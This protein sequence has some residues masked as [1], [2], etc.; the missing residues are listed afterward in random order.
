MAMFHRRKIVMQKNAPPFLLLSILIP[1]IVAA[2]PLLAN[3]KSPQNQCNY[4]IVTPK[5]FFQGAENLAQFR[6][7]FS[8]Y[9]TG[10]VL[11]D[12][13]YAQF[14]SVGRKPF[15]KLW[16]GLKY[17]ST[18]WAVP[19][20]FVVLMGADTISFN[21]TDSTWKNCGDMPAFA[22]Q[23][24]FPYS[25][26]GVQHQPEFEY[27]DDYY[28]ELGYSAPPNVAAGIID[29]GYK[30]VIGRI[31]CDSA[32][33]CLNYVQ[34][35]IDF[36][37]N[38][39]RNKS[40]FNSA[41]VVSDDTMQALIPDPLGFMHLEA[42]EICADSLLRSWFVTKVIGCAYAPDSMTLNKPQVED[43][44]V[45]DLNCGNL[46]SVYV[47]HAGPDVWSDEQMLLGKDAARLRNDSTPSVF[48][49]FSCMNADY[50]APYGNS[51][52]KQF[53]F[54][55][56]GGALAYIA[57]TTNTYSSNN[58]RLMEFLFNSFN[59]NQQICLGT[60]LLTAKVMCAD[61][62][63][64]YY[65]CLG[66]PALT[67]SDGSLS[68]GMTRNNQ[69]LVSFTC[70]IGTAAVRSGNFDVR[71]YKRDTV[72]IGAKDFYCLDSLVSRQTGTFTNGNFAAA[73]A[74][75][76]VRI[77][78]YVWNENGEGRM[79][80]SFLV[81]AMPVIAGVHEFPSAVALRIENG[82]VFIQ[83]GSL[84]GTTIRLSALA[85]NGR[86]A[87][88]RDIPV[89]AREITVDPRSMGLAAGTYLV[90]LA[91]VGG[92]FTQRMILAK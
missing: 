57:A 8:G 11:L 66:D 17:A 67:L 36:E 7:S 52:C 64:R 20:Q 4:L 48:A 78:A 87:L 38:K 51:M 37:N 62:N 53:L 34:K 91:T 68:L 28:A 24:D 76:G 35:V 75:T 45:N 2:Q 50:L 80:S 43:S 72:R 39:H 58:T 82:R 31:P 69:D 77:V 56:H 33:Q 73:V 18:A 14:D 74:D 46:W 86:V 83:T 61:F 63:S 26:S 23:C 54:A 81:N 71:I 55:S 79:D 65:A 22:Y 32:Q 13:I 16:W 42:A 3:F 89:N 60:A 5:K 19:P 15:E 10:V 12:S 44:I 59:G 90:R 27:S 25:D 70:R 1:H 40:W 47:G 21:F 85:M 29:T 84:R 30:F 49:S 92:C 9:K 6:Q 88:S 41:L